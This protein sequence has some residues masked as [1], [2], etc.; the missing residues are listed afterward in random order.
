MEYDLGVRI[1]SGLVDSSTQPSLETTVFTYHRV[2]SGD[3]NINGA[4][5][6]HLEECSM[7]LEFNLTA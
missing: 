3:L 6:G 5:P 7:T 1:Q 4:E 2:I